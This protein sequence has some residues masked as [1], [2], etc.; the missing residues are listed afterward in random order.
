MKIEVDTA[1]M[2]RA[3]N[4][5]AAAGKKAPLAIIRAVNHTGDK[6]RNAMRS[7]LVGQTGLKRKTINKAVKSTRAFNGGAYVIRA[8]GGNIRLKFFS[9]RE[10]RSGVSAAPWN[11]RRVYPRTFL[12]GGRFPNRKPLNVGG[13]VLER[14]G[15][16]RKPLRT[17]R[18]GLYIAE[19]LVSGASHDA[20]YRVVDRDLPARIAHELYRVIGS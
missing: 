2:A 13:Q 4:L 10:T 16:G 8:E 14:K 11:K 6:A 5:F 1:P 19:E 7:V 18:S 3:A 20:F 12:K 15:Q 9:P 17:V